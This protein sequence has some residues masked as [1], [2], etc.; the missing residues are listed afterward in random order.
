VGR[1]M[2]AAIEVLEIKP[3]NGLG[4]LRAFAKV[5]LGCVVI[6]GCRVIQQPNQRP[7]CALPQVPARKKADG[8]GAGWFPVV[9][10]TNRN[11]L[12]QVRAAVLEAWEAR[13]TAPQDR[14]D[15]PI[16]GGRQA[17]EPLEERADAWSK[18]QRDEVP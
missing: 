18:R 2:T 12:D 8:S 15:L 6:H 17:H 16:R 1:A 14:R 10:I 9:E 11:V 7:W 13:C 4:N 5:K 3:V